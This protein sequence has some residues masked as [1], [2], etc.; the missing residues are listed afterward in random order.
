MQETARVRAD[1]TW[2]CPLRSATATAMHDKGHFDEQPWSCNGVSKS[3]DWRP[4][5]SLRGLWSPHRWERD[6]VWVH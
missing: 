4:G 5:S 3:T 6:G 1:V 2:T